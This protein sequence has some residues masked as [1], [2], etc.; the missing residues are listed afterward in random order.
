MPELAQCL[1]IAE[2]TLRDWCKEKHL[3]SLDSLVKVIKGLSL[4]RA[5]N[6]FDA[7]ESFLASVAPQLNKQFNFNV[8][9]RAKSAWQEIA[10]YISEILSGA[11]EPETRKSIADRFEVSIGMLENA[12]KSEMILIS[13]PYQQKKYRT[14]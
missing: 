5:S 12:F 14:K 10:P 9:R 11:R 1:G 8:K 7:P 4:P 13:W 2:S 6:L 3:L